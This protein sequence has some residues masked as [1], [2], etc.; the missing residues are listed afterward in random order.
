MNTVQEIHYYQFIGIKA[1]IH[2]YTSDSN[3]HAHGVH[4]QTM[5]YVGLLEFRH[6]H[7]HNVHVHAQ[8]V[9]Q[10]SV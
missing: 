6:T 1:C 9:A 4:A 3:S 10:L 7:G 2:M 8:H 5:R